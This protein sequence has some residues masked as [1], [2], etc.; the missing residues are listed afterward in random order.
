MLPTLMECLDDTCVPSSLYVSH[1]TSS[2][3]L[4]CYPCKDGVS[5]VISYFPREAR[6]RR[7]DVLPSRDMSIMQFIMVD[8][9]L[10]SKIQTEHRHSV[11]PY[12][13]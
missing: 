4:C 3:S 2:S 6:E 1:V 5:K 10:R 9:C 12:L 13:E 7:V 11:L 8:D